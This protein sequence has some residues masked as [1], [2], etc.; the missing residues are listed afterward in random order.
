MCQRRG[1]S[2][3]VRA[4]RT[5]FLCRSG[6]LH[7]YSTAPRGLHEYATAP[8]GSYATAPCGSY[9]H[10]R[11]VALRIL[12][13]RVDHTGEVLSGATLLGRGVA[14]RGGVVG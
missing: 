11:G 10:G 13:L 12:I 1:R 7:E 8:R 14:A 6:G 2:C 3:P 9:D 4:R 5:H